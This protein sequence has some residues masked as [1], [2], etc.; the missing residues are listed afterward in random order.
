VVYGGNSVWCIIDKCRL[1]TK[2][3][4]LVALAFPFLC[5]ALTLRDP[6]PTSRFGIA[7]G[8]SPSS[9]IEGESHTLSEGASCE[10]VYFSFLEGFSLLPKHHNSY[11]H[12]FEFLQQYTPDTTD[13]CSIIIQHQPQHQLLSIDNAISVTTHSNAGDLLSS[14][15]TSRRAVQDL[16]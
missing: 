12:I 3:S 16:R 15:R 11:I 14:I 1:A 10:D 9:V 5:S 7:G 2:E 13:T 8:R 6:P 4:D